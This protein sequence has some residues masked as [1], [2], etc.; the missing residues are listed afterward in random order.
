VIFCTVVVAVRTILHV[1]GVRRVPSAT[2]PEGKVT[3]AVAPLCRI[4]RGAGSNTSETRRRLVPHSSFLFLLP[5][6]SLNALHFCQGH[7]RRWVTSSMGAHPKRFYLSAA[8]QPDRPDRSRACYD[9]VPYSDTPDCPTSG[10]CYLGSRN[11]GMRPAYP[12]LLTR[13]NRRT[14]TWDLRAGPGEEHD[15]VA[16]LRCRIL[17]SPPVW[18]AVASHLTPRIRA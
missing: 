17:F 4:R 7:L 10:H 3:S 5:S 6:F 14:G 9:A 18:D 12:K 13:K 15:A 11:A 1:S 16:L 8:D 2:C